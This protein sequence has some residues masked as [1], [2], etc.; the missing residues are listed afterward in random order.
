VLHDT[1]EQAIDF[2]R[3]WS[4]RAH[5]AAW[6]IILWLGLTPSKFHNWQSRQGRVNEHNGWIPRDFWL[7][8]WEKRAILDFHERYPLESYR[9]LTFMMLGADLVAVRPASVWRV[10]HQAGR[11]CRWKARPSGK[12]K[13]FQQPLGAHEH[14]HVDVSLAVLLDKAIQ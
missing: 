10:L 9:R 14:W 4:Q 12:G 11:L 1:R 8:G 3:H 5:L 7:Q 6:R 13:G 2:V